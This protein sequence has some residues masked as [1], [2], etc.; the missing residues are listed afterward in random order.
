[1]TSPQPSSDYQ[2]SAVRLVM[3]GSALQIAS[4]VA[5]LGCGVLLMAYLT[6]RL[7]TAE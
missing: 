2:A 5:V 6:R 3:V 7:G 1:V 4:R